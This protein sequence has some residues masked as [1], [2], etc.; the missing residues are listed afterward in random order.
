MQR[1]VHLVLC[2]SRF[3][4]LITIIGVPA[5]TPDEIYTYDD[6]YYECIRKS[7]KLAR[8]MLDFAMS[9][10]RVGISTEEIDKIVHDE[11]IKNNAYPSPINYNGFPKAI[12]TSI[13]EV[14]C[15]GIPDS[16]LIQEGDVIS[17]D[18]SLYLD[19]CHGDNCGTMIVGEG[20]ENAKKLVATTKEALDAAIS[21]CK[22]GVCLTKIGQT[23]QDYAHERGFRVV[24][25]FA[26]HGTGPYLHMLPLV[27][28]FSNNFKCELSPGMV[29][30]I[31]PILVEGSRKISLWK[32]GWSAF[33]LDGGRGAQFEH[34]V[35][36]TESGAEVLTVP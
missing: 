31:E 21:I 35:L 8:K 23:I 27:Y 16:R 20:D 29:F 9:L 11:I 4:K 33:T 5:K 1:Q 26:G 30:T 10:V 22:P 36:I 17:I 6:E 2:I 24:H 12:C 25:E 28:H 18:V 15:H 14:V 19:G 32:D 34:E 3:I 7:A 13:N